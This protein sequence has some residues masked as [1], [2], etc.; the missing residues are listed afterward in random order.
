M[1]SQPLAQSADKQVLF[2]RLGLNE[3]AHKLLLQEA[4]VARDSLS[5]NPRNL[6]DQSRVNKYIQMPY[7]WDEI[8]ETAKHREILTV[9]NNA[10]PI[11][12][13][14]YTLGRYQTT[15][16]EENWVARWYLWH[17][18][19]YRDNRE[20]RQRTAVAVN[21]GHGGRQTSGL[22]IGGTASGTGGRYWDPA[23]DE[24]SP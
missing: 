24:N 5:S 19:R 2:A 1:S 6:T 11:T 7:K 14:F 23:R 4:Q 21:R 12:K 13:Y 16:N 8:S 15:V 9:V 17:S 3:Q 20:P 22:P 10:P 18:F